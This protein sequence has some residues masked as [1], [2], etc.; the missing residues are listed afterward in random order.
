M[1]VFNFKMEKTGKTPWE[2]RYLHST[3]NLLF[4]KPKKRAKWMYLIMI[5]LILALGFA[6]Q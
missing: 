4:G 3:N 6:F 1:N 2:K 5:V